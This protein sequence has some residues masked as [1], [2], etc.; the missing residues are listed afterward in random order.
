MKLLA[1]TEL[2]LFFLSER[3]FRQG[4]LGIQQGDGLCP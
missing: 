1:F 4:L 2:G 3:L